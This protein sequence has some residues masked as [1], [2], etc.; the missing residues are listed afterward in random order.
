MLLEQIIKRVLYQYLDEKEQK[1]FKTP[2]K[3]HIARILH[4]KKWDLPKRH[5]AVHTKIVT[6]S[7]PF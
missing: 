3:N 6:N 4:V 1:K 7:L 5:L 2:R